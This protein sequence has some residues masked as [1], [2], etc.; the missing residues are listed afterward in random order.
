MPGERSWVLSALRLA[1]LA[2]VLA[3]LIFTRWDLA[4]VSLATLGLSF[5]PV[6]IA[7][8][9][10]INLPIPFLVFTT[11][12]LMGSIF[13]GEAFNFYERLWWW[14]IALHGLSAISFGLIGFLFV[15]T[16]FEGDRYAAP[17]LAIAV[18]SFTCAVTIGTLWEV[19]EFAMDKVFGLNMQ[20]SG[21][22]DTMLDLIVDAIGAFVGATFGWLYLQG[23]TRNWATGLIAEFV[24]RNR[25]LYRKA[26]R[27]RSK[28]D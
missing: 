24:A 17:A 16:L 25:H 19:F 28:S 1:L 7:N 6:V 15:F 12:F 26:R 8:R 14:D 3:A 22:D 23:R 10:H 21:L 9:F 13:M 18:L 11:L 27:S 5:V 2:A 20:K 4:F